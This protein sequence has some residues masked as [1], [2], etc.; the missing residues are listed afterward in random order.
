MRPTP[1]TK[2]V[3]ETKMQFAAA[4]SQQS[5][6]RGG[7]DHSQGDVAALRARIM[8]SSL[9]ERTRSLH[10]DLEVLEKAMAKEVGDPSTRKL[11]RQDQIARNQARDSERGRNQETPGARSPRAPALTSRARDA[12]QAVATCTASANLKGGS[13]VA[14]KIA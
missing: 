9:L 10:E 7:R 6:R 1:D 4:A 13:T 5:S 8:S 2:Y 3:A 12:S 14:F 11:G